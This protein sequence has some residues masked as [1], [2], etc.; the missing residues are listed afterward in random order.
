MTTEILVIDDDP[1]IRQLLRTC[2]ER[3]GYSVS[4]ASDAASARTALAKGGVNLVTLDLTLGRD[5][6]LSLAREI[7]A[8]GD[9]PI[10]MV[11]GK[12]DAVDRIVGLE[13][14]ADDYISKPFNLREVLARVRAVLRRRDAGGISVLTAEAK[15]ESYQFG[16]WTLDATSRALKDSSGTIRE[17]TTGEFNLLEIFVRRPHRVL[18]R[19]EI[20][21]L[22]KGHDYSP[23][24]RSIDALVSRLRK[25]IDDDGS[26]AAYIKSVRGI[27]Y[28]LATD[29]RRI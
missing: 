5:D 23:L 10:V 25:K 19:D 4:E 6:G 7:R 20:M 16:G 1:D 11:S 18:S 26:N 12:G 28:M 2:F 3:E 14:G 21:D 24:D 27:G 22:L 8:N 13:L 17:L 15:H 29:V 9:I